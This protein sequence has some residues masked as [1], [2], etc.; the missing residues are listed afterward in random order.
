[1]ESLKNRVLFLD[2]DGPICTDRAYFAS[3]HNIHKRV[4]RA[5]DQTCIKM[6]DAIALKYQMR[7]VISSTWRKRFDVPTILMTHGFRADYHKDDK[8]QDLGSRAL[9]IQTWLNDH[10]KVDTYLIVDDKESG[11]SLINDPLSKYTIFCN[12]FEG[13]GYKDYMN[14]VNILNRRIN[15]LK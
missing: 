7:I 1:M 6:I 8:T 13:F 3:E 12:V 2:I 9:D 15:E 4:M 11:S 5:W 10:P 14:S